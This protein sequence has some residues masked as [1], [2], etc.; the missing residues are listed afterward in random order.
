M[1]MSSPTS[2]LR[3]RFERRSRRL[4]VAREVRESL[5]SVAGLLGRPVCH[6]D[7]APVGK[8]VDVV[9]HWD[10]DQAYPP[11]AGIVTKVG[12]R[13]AYVPAAVIAAVDQRDV[14][15][16]TA[17]LDL[18]DFTPRAGETAL[19]MQVLDH[20][21]VDIDG[22]RVVRAADLYLATIGATV[23]L[24]GVDVSVESLL[25]RLGPARWRTR[26]TPD[27]VIDW[28]SVQSFGPAAGRGGARLTASRGELNR[29]RPAELADL[30]EDL[31]RRERRELLELVGRDAAAD[32]LEEMNAEQLHHL[33][34]ETDP[35]HAADLV[36]RMEPDEAAEALRGLADDDRDALLAAMPDEAVDR[37]RPVL[38]ADAGSAGGEM[39]TLLLVAQPTDTV[40]DVRRR[41]AEQAEHVV[42]LD[43]II[44]VD[45]DGRLVDDVSL[46]ELFIADPGTS[47]R[48][49]IG[50][51]WPVTVGP[52]ADVR[53]VA[54]RLIDSRRLSVVVL[55]D[56]DRPIGR[57][58][59]DD[60]LDAVVAGRGRWQFPRPR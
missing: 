18:R 51:P 14:R 17:R 23:R 28:A 15:L 59:A 45:A 20:Q 9:A 22:A 34:T 25:R 12:A 33:L 31:G 57:I 6:R 16:S 60:I 4:E 52:D 37:L 26:P 39:T 5:V 44:V 42:D 7:G 53:E 43:A 32:A 8:V 27:A 38:R 21:L 40:A 47:L 41:L 13:R 3:H 36:A 55:D 19:A 50:P 46:G 48:E 2:A 49:L 11:L 58:L 10:T 29:L 54:E 1:A 35:A 56:Q 30:L 24:V